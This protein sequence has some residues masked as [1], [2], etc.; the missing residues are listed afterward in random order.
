MRS[1]HRILLSGAAAL[2]AASVATAVSLWGMALPEELREGALKAEAAQQDAQVTKSFTNASAKDVI[3]WLRSQTDNLVIDT[4]E[5]P[6]RKLTMNVKGQDLDDVIE[7]VATALNM[8][9]TKKGDIYVL[10]E[11][12]M[13]MFRS[14]EGEMP[15]FDFDFDGL[16]FDFEGMH[17]GDKRV[18]RF[19]P[20]FKESQDWETFKKEMPELAEK[21]EKMR[22]EFE[23]MGD[24]NVF[25]FDSNFDG[26]W[27]E[28]RKIKPEI[29]E[30]LEKMRIEL[31]GLGEGE[32]NVFRFG[33][34]FDG[35][36]SELEEIRPEVREK[37]RKLRTEGK[38]MSFRLGKDLDLKKLKESMTDRQKELMNDR[39]YLKLSDLTDAQKEMLGELGDGKFE[40]SLSDGDTK[41]KIKSDD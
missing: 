19:G 20:D 18:F 4:T 37:L 2:G 30:K 27:S 26:D 16:D 25:R 41:I 36:W 24:R 11:G 34:G 3:N 33:P 38:G 39:G 15:D 35:D 17:D 5:L 13:N 40:I 7:A 9:W 10:R 23:D 29:A 22:L 31:K 1:S 32:G 8:G 21:L 6:D 14:F 28:L 12:G